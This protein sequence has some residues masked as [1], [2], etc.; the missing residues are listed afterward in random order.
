VRLD[1]PV[2]DVWLRRDGEV[3]ADKSYRAQGR[4]QRVWL[5]A[6]RRA[7]FWWDGAQGELVAFGERPA[8]PVELGY[9]LPPGSNLELAERRLLDGAGPPADASPLACRVT[10]DRQNRACLVAPAPTR[11]R[12]DV[13]AL[14][15][16]TLVLAA[17]VL[18]LGLGTS[19]GDLVR[20][21]GGD[22]VTFAVEVSAAGA[23][24]ETTERVW[25]RHVTAA[26]GFV[27]AAVDLAGWRGRAASLRLVTEP[28]PRQD[29]SFD[30]ALWSGLRLMGPP[31]RAPQRPN[32]VLVDVD[33]LR[34]DR[35]GCY[36]YERPTTPRIDAWARA[37]AT[38][39]ADATSAGNWTLPSTVSMLTGLS[40]H[41]HGSRG[42]HRRVPAGASI[43]GRLRAA[44]YETLARTDGGFLGVDHGFEEGFDLFHF[45]SIKRSDAPSWAPE[46]ERLR[47]RASERPVFYF[48]QTYLVHAP[49]GGDTRFL[50]AYDGP[51]AGT[52]KPQ[53]DLVR[54]VRNGS[55]ELGEDDWAY[56]NALYDGGVRRMDGVVGELLEGLEEVFAGQDLLV[57]VTSDHGEELSERGSIGHDH[58]L[59]RELLHVPLLVRFPEGDRVGVETRPVGGLDVAP[60]ILDYAG[61]LIPGALPGRSLRGPLPDRRP[62]IVAHEG[63]ASAVLFD[64]WKL[65]EGEL[66]GTTELPLLVDLSRD[67]WERTNLHDLEPERVRELTRLREGF[68]ESYPA[69]PAQD[70]EARALDEGTLEE[71]RALGYIGDE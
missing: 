20:A 3:V 63:M 69:L 49:Y 44:G 34:A 70:T 64:G 21:D 37:R 12:L 8:A 4:E 19:D 5:D 57:I 54:S 36:G 28:G 26:E 13:G 55:T 67:P 22:G 7:L 47:A 23:T 48:L 38:V 35:L 25:S 18:D 32:I 66:H 58:S 71:L 27:E 1:L 40:A 65:I 11:L 50:P 6:P 59:H 56:V 29:A 45:D 30:Y 16:D 10:L 46:L 68:E 33:T 39:Y 51:L 43:A 24:E 52:E 60:T 41:Q 15:G 2:G 9:R 62:Q 42:M 17:G 31:R 61:V 14:D 53:R